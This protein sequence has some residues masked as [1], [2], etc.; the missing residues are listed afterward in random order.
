MKTYYKYNL[1]I[2]FLHQFN[3]EFC[4]TLLLGL[5]KDV[6]LHTCAR[7]FDSIDFIEYSINSPISFIILCN[8]LLDKLIWKI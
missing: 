7:I 5:L 4:D 2:D 8:I 3:L 6:S 1:Y